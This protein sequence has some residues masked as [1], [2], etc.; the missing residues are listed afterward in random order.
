MKVGDLV[1]RI[2]DG[3][4]WRRDNEGKL[5]PNIAVGFIVEHDYEKIRVYWGDHGMHWCP[6][7]RVELV[8]ESR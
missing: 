7:D 5:F 8:N 4:Y 6:V 1:Q 2:D 3:H